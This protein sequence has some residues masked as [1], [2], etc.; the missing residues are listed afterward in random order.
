MTNISVLHYTLCG[1]LESWPKFETLIAQ[2]HLELTIFPKQYDM[3]VLVWRLTFLQPMW[4]LHLTLDTWDTVRFQRRWQASTMPKM[5]FSAEFTCKYLPLS[6]RGKALWGSVLSYKTPDVTNSY[7][8][9][10]N[11]RPHC[12]L[13]ST[14]RLSGDSQP[15]PL[16]LCRQDELRQQAASG[17]FRQWGLEKSSKGFAQPQHLKDDS[18][19]CVARLKAPFIRFL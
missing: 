7:C 1:N 3:M 14:R 9:R 15:A 6:H 5:R 10:Q 8:C 18:C 2:L 16:L 13:H 4:F 17:S 19:L 12:H 11:N